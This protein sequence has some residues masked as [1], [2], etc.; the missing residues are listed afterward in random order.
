[1]T[2]IVNISLPLSLPLSLSVTLQQSI[3]V[4]PSQSG[5]RRVASCVRDW[6]AVPH[7]Q[8]SDKTSGF[9]VWDDGEQA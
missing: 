4:R 2:H 3:Y 8:P 5:E 7:L 9:R 6:T 1:M